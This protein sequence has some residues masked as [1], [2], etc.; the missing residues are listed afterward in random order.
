MRGV[1]E[2]IYKTIQV[3][4]IQIKYESIILSDNNKKNVIT[5][6]Q[7]KLIY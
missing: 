2:I 3:K 5:L 6:Q 7:I 1:R 4:N